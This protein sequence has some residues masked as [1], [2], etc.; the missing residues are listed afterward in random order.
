ML[1]GD[2]RDLTRAILARTTGPACG[3]A[4]EVLVEG[5]EAPSDAT[6][7]AL[8]AAHLDE[9]AECQAF[10]AAWS[11]AAGTLPRLAEIDPGPAFSVEV[12]A[13][14]TRRPVSAWAAWW[15]RVVARP[16]FSLEVAYVGA[17]LC[18]LLVGNP[19][20]LAGAVAERVQLMTSEPAGTAA[21]GGDVRSSGAGTGSTRPAFDVNSVT[22]DS[23]WDKLT[24][25][26]FGWLKDLETWMSD[27]WRR[28]SA[29][30]GAKS[31]SAGPG[32]ADERSG[33]LLDITTDAPVASEG[34]L[35]GHRRV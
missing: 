10:E 6:T 28:L 1:P 4:R 35:P 22:T 11:E 27:V 13:A 34:N 12:L 16:H 23:W 15:A 32:S 8:L 9:C 33:H 18:V 3:R 2:R 29:L 30:F 25:R 31:E 5:S 19:I 14:T 7:G 17:C 21:P 26:A 20:S 24:A